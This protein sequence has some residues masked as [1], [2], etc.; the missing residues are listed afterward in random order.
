MNETRYIE[1]YILGTLSAEENTVFEAKLLIDDELAAK[2]ALQQA[3]H[4]TVLACGR[5]QLRR[6]IAA[7]DKKLFT[8]KR[9]GR[10]QQ[11]VGKIFHP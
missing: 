1:H 3:L 4:R 10:F 8:A 7:I 6:E 11:I 9:Y 2:T 5:N